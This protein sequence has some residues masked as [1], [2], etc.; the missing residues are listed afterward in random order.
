MHQ[1]NHLLSVLSKLEE[2]NITPE[3]FIQK[4]EEKE[5]LKATEDKNVI[6]EEQLLVDKTEKIL[7]LQK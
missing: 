7:K 5:A 2:S 3:S 6:K 1:A 4:N